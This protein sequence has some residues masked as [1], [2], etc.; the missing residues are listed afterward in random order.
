[1]NN[2]VNVPSKSNEQ[3]NFKKI[4][5][6]GVLKVNDEN[7]SIRIPIFFNMCKTFGRICM[8]KGIV[9]ISIR[10]RNGI[11][12]E[13]WIWMGDAD[14]QHWEQILTRRA[15]HIPVRQIKSVTLYLLLCFKCCQ[16]QSLLDE[17]VFRIRI[18]M[19]LGLPDPN[20]DP[21]VRGMD[22][23]PDPSIIMQKY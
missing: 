7:S 14:P 2:D 23:D 1:L 9:L 4:V 21:L 15:Y 18:H 22:P 3:K 5:F 8:R 20:P 17:A 13:I 11:H 19:F 6:V 12:V 10:I 16:V